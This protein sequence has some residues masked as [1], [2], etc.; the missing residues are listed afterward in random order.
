MEAR[1]VDW[2][3]KKVIFF[4]ELDDFVTILTS[5]DFICNARSVVVTSYL[6][7]GRRRRK[8][9]FTVTHL[10]ANPARRRITSMMR[11]IILPLFL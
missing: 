1:S 2:H 5:N 11:S 4:T 7:Q 8:I 9:R 10:T 3:R 6:R